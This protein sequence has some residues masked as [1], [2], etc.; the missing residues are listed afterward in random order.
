M[1]PVIRLDRRAS[2]TFRLRTEIDSQ[3]GRRDKD[4]RPAER[5]QS[6]SRKPYGNLRE[7]T[8]GRRPESRATSDIFRLRGL[9]AP[10]YPASK[11]EI[12]GSALLSRFLKWSIVFGCLSRLSGVFR[13]ASPKKKSRARRRRNA[14]SLRYCALLSGSFGI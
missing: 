2:I 8:T 3:I 10:F 14:K 7:S 13:V 12:L 11:A 5:L 9:R 1:Y 6:T 4:F